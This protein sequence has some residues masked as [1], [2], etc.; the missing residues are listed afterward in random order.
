MSV[1]IMP[2][3]YPASWYLDVC[4]HARFQGRKVTHTSNLTANVISITAR[5]SRR[6]QHRWSHLL[7]RLH[8]RLHLFSSRQLLFPSAT[9]RH[10]FDEYNGAGRYESNLISHFE[11]FY[12]MVTVCITIS[13]SYIMTTFLLWQQCQ[14]L[15]LWRMLMSIFLMELNGLK[16]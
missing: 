7:Q 16:P 5:A 9:H 13:L 14:S 3:C 6:L 4:T 2:V 11:S 12:I 8:H 10:T 1:C 15:S